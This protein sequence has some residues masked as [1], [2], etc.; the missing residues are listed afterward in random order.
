MGGATSGELRLPGAQTGQID[1][2]IPP[3]LDSIMARFCFIGCPGRVGGGDL[4]GLDALDDHAVRPR[5]LNRYAELAAEN[6]I[7]QSLYVNIS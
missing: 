6:G 7:D 5:G 1:F 4:Q 3:K 2:Q